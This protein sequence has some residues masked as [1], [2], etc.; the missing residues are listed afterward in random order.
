MPDRSILTEPIETLELSHEFKAMARL[1]GFST[2]QEILNEALDELHELPGSGFRMLKELG[3][4]LAAH[5]LS[6]LLDN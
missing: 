3:D 6:N 4:I 5:G 1:N 2:L